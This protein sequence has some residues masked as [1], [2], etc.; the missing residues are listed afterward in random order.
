MS[1]SIIV[2]NGFD[3][4]VVL[5]SPA[6]AERMV[7]STQQ[8]SSSAPAAPAVSPASAA[9]AQRLA[10]QQQQQHPPHKAAASPSRAAEDHTAQQAEAAERPKS[11]IHGSNGAGGAGEQHQV[12]PSLQLQVLV[13]WK[14]ADW[15]AGAAEA[16]ISGVDMRPENVQA[17][18]TKVSR[19]PADTLLTP[20]TK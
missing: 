4:P 11:S 6:A 19:R 8:P 20:R 12:D 15:T 1:C 18:F 9:A 5:A 14:S 7:S 10:Q 3:N 2:A 13:A 16:D 17:W